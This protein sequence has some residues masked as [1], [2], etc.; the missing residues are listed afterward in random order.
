MNPTFRPDKF[1]LIQAPDFNK[2]LDVLGRKLILK[3]KLLK[4]FVKALK[5]E[6][7]TFMLMAAEFLTM[8]CNMFLL[9]SL[10]N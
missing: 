7:N 10:Q 1:L 4:T 3:L 8:V 2:Y 5:K 6:L 9:I